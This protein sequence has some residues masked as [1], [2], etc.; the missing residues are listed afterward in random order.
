[1]K[2]GDWFYGGETNAYIAFHK[3]TKL[4]TDGQGNALVFYTTMIV[5]EER[6]DYEEDNWPLLTYRGYRIVESNIQKAIRILFGDED[7]I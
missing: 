4:D 1:M 6:I 7:V 3:I 2:V 5:R